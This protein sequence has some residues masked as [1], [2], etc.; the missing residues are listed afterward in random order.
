ME[1]I[2]EDFD[3]NF[4]IADSLK[5]KVLLLPHSTD[6]EFKGG[7][8]TTYTQSSLNVL[9]LFQQNN[10]DTC[11]ALS[12]PKDVVLIEN[13]SADWIGPTLFFSMSLISQ[14][15]NI[16]SICLNVLSAYIYDIFKGKQEN[17]NVRCSFV[18]EDKKKNKKYEYEGP[19]SGLNEMRKI[20]NG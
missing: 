3:L 8:V 11:F 18:I 9:K 4:E 19:V 7:K 6:T 14:N 17:T 12:T 2:L 13:R 5:E 1:Q 15:P 16:I 10:I 20:I